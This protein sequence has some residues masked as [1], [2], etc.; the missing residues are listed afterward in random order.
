MSKNEL[1]SEVVLKL[2][3]EQLKK[4]EKEC[5]EAFDDLRW[6]RKEEKAYYKLQIKQLKKTKKELKEAFENAKWE[7][8]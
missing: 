4:V 2:E 3:I 5:S 6:K 7:T 8:E 1:S